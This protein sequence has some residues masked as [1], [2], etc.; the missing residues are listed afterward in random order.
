MSLMDELGLFPLLLLVPHPARHKIPKSTN[1]FMSF[2]LC[3][4]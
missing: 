3:A 2:L 4:G 1:H